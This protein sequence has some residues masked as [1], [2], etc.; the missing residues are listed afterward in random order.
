MIKKSITFRTLEGLVQSECWKR[1]N[2]IVVS[3]MYMELLNNIGVSLTTLIH[4]Q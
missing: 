3:F 2:R 1:E 4:V